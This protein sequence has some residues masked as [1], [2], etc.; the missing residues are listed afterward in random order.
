LRCRVKKKNEAHYSLVMQFKEAHCKRPLKG[1]NLRYRISLTDF[2][3]MVLRRV[4]QFRAR[5]RSVT[6]LLTAGVCNGNAFTCRI[7]RSQ[8]RCV[9]A[10][11]GTV[12]STYCH[13]LSRGDSCIANIYRANAFA[14]A[15]NI[16]HLSN[17]FCAMNFK[18]GTAN[19]NAFAFTP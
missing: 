2:L 7:R 1:R 11:N 12:T 14:P 18:R 17:A 5:E 19:L 13:T 8:S 10:G 6:I 4:L 15:T 3:K 9:Y 16:R